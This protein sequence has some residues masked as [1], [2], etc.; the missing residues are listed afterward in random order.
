MNQTSISDLIHGRVMLGKLSATGFYSVKCPICNDYQSRMGIKFEGET[1]GVNCFNCGFGARY[2]ESD[3]RIN[4][5]FKQLLVAF[6]IPFDEV[7]RADSL[8]FFRKKEPEVI[9]LASIN[10][11]SLFTPDV[12]LPDKSKLIT[13][14]NYPLL[15]QYIKSR[16]LTNK[17]YTFFGSDDKFYTN[18]VI[19]PFYRYGKL[20]YW[21]ARSIF[22]EEKRRYIN[23]D[24]PKEAI[25]FNIEQ[26][27]NKS[28]ERLFVTE[29]VID[30]I[31][32]NGV[33][34]IG[35][36]LNEAKIEL[37]KQSRREL[38]FVIDHNKNGYH[39]AETVLQYGL[40]K[41]T[42]PSSA[43]NGNKSMDI[44]ETIRVYGK[45]WACYQLVQNI[46]KTDFQQKLFLNNFKTR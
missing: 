3:N 36:K 37:L 11:V 14:E 33:S 27:H 18:R 26:L 21:Q 31:H 20:I 8:L 41:I 35:S 45:L 16:N 9:T 25:I 44:D 7:E 30:A 2:A 4:K 32:V 1:I 15:N 23:C 42:S 39:L 29:G 28:D 24:T 5:K 34:I 17:S 6:N 13:D 46:P 22:K 10:K 12:R 40:G 38:V 43:L 19:I